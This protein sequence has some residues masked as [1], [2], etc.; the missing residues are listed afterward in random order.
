MGGMSLKFVAAASILSVGS[1]TLALPSNAQR[2][3]MCVR[4][5]WPVGCATERSVA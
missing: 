1:V 2:V 3:V 5:C 4:S